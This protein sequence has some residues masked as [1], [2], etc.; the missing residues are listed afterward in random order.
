MRITLSVWPLNR[1]GIDE[2]FSFLR[3]SRRTLGKLHPFTGYNESHES[4]E[5]V[6]W[7]WAGPTHFCVT[8][9]DE[10]LGGKICWP[11]G[12]SISTLS[13]LGSGYQTDLEGFREWTHAREA[14][15]PHCPVRF[16][17]Q[18]KDLYPEMKMR[19]SFQ[20]YDVERFAIPILL[21]ALIHNRAGT[22]IRRRLATFIFLVCS[23]HPG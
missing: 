3:K 14:S 18:P 2:S 19:L 15:V 22:R 23:F 8:K 7:H 5:S 9:Q 17:P 13:S 21:V 1:R 4:A 12:N 16:P 20:T 10:L 6:D 11:L